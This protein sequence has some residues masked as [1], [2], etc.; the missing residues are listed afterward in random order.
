MMT[1]QNQ[2]DENPE[3]V[4]TER[5]KKRTTVKYSLIALFMFGFGFALSPMYTLFCQLAG[6]NGRTV[7]A[8]NAQVDVSIDTSRD[9]KVRFITTTHS[10]LPWEFEANETWITV[11]PGEVNKA[12]FRVK[13]NAKTAITGQAIPSL[14]P[15]VAASHF[16][17]TECFCFD[18][19]TLQPGEV[20]DMPLQFYIDPN[21]PDYIG[22]VFL[23]YQF[24]NTEKKQISTSTTASLGIYK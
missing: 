23:T 15:T 20:A 1:D 12:T 2:I 13:N 9:I 21:V 6:L 18:T 3:V 16:I 8:K 24:F 10:D 5:R 19:Q 14:A 22:S 17:K 7:N 4:E 11:H